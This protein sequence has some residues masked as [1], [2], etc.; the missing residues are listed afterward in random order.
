[1]PACFSFS[2][3]SE[4]QYILLIIIFQGM[5]FLEKIRLQK[6]IAMCGV[7]SRRKA[8][9]LISFGA[10]TVNGKT[11]SQLGSKVLPGDE[12]RIYDEIIT[13]CS[14]KIYIMLNKPSGVI[15]AARDEYAVTVTQLIEDEIEERLIPVGR[16]DKKTEGLLI[17]TNDGEAV[18]YLTHPKY[19]VE[20]KY[21]AVVR[22]EIT[23]DIVRRLERGVMVD[24]RLTL[25]CKI[26]LLREFKDRTELNI[27]ISEG[28]NRQIRK[29]FQEV[30]SFVMQLRRIAVGPLIL[31]NLP[32]GRFRRLTSGEISFIKNLCTKAQSTWSRSKATEDRQLLEI[33]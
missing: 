13:P 2:A 22:G 30:G 28:R 26:E 12:V 16:L 31:G 23:P 4:P 11:V 17:L 15:T 24:G 19:K 25:P 21:T 5:V 14:R 1:M 33:L 3:V 6:Y 7:A 10:V 27:T 32:L 9:E 29:M 18:Y 8:E 20:K